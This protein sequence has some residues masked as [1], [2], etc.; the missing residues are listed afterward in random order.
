MANDDLLRVTNIRVVK[1]FGTYTHDVPLRT[2]DRVTIIHGPN[3]V[4]KT[5]LFRLVTA[6]LSGNF[7]EL[8]KV[9][10]MTFEVT[11]SNG[12]IL[13]CSRTEPF[14]KKKEDDALATCYLLQGG[15]TLH[16]L[17]IGPNQLDI[18]RLASRIER[19]MPWMSQIDEDR[20]LD[21]RTDEVFTSSELPMYYL[22]FASDRSK[23]PDLLFPKAEWMASIRDRVNVHLV[24]AQRLLK[25]SQRH[26]EWEPSRQRD[27]FIETVKTYAKDLQSRISETLTLYAKQSQSMDQSFPQRLLKSIYI[28]VSVDDL[29]LRMK[30]LEDY[31]TRLKRIGLI[32]E[33]S[34]YPFDVRELEK[35][36]AT[37]RTVMTLYV[38]DT[39]KKLGVLDDLAS[40]IEILIENINRK[41]AHKSVLIDREKGLIAR[42]DDK[43]LLELDALSSGE[44]HELVLLYDLLF[45]IKP[46]TLVLIDE[47]ELS[48]HVTWQK[49]FLPDL[50]KVVEATGYDVVLATHS[51]FIVGDREDLMVPL[52]IEADVTPSTKKP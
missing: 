22:K 23:K 44:Q 15:K 33:D 45:R 30:K 26:R 47:P 41:F 8:L 42:T 37:Q 18:R 21:R 35:L 10:F 14:E 16:S 34:A 20:F 27:H 7:I 28:P 12:T 49:S 13:G 19:E 46:N 29:K 3:G 24:E 36:D 51:P 1:L 25:V 43:Q 32:A 17:D 38:E 11:L 9:P 2:Q 48:L 39:G 5:V 6:L 50:I 4:G 52:S 31:R 40:R